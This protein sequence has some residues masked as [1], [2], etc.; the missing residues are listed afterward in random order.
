MIKPESKEKPI[1]VRVIK[2]TKKPRSYLENRRPEK[3]P[4]PNRVKSE[5]NDE[6]EERKKKTI[7]LASV[8]AVML[9]I[10]IVWFSFLGSNLNQAGN[11]NDSFWQRVMANVKDEYSAIKDRFDKTTQDLKN[12]NEDAGQK[13]LEENVFPKIK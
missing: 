6:P 8:I 10:V 7:V 4:G 2:R 12:T 9:V 1:K 11:R 5:K 3:Y 13:A